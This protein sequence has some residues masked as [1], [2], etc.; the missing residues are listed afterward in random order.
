MQLDGGVERVMFATD[1]PIQSYVD[2]FALV[3]ALGLKPS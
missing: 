3:E 1:F 2:T